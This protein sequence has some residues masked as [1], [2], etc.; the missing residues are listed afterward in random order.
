[1]AK[2]PCARCAPRLALFVA[3]LTATALLVGEP[4][5]GGAADGPQS[6]ST[7]EGDVRMDV[8]VD[9]ALAGS[10]EIHLYLFDAEDGSQYDE[11]KDVELQ[12]SLPEDDIGPIDVERR[13]V[14]PRPLHGARRCLGR[15]RDV[16]ARALRAHLPLRRPDRISGDRNRLT[17]K[18][19]ET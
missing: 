1:M 9:P 13:E 14:R 18:Q 6:A 11:P 3:V 17:T 2:S 5:P 16:G 10:N 4:P 8:T 7:T 15:A 12:A 19:K